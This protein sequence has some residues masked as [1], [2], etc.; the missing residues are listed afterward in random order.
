MPFPLEVAPAP[1]SCLTTLAGGRGTSP[2]ASRF[3][4]LCWPALEAGL[5]DVPAARLFALVAAVVAVTRAVITVLGSLVV[6][7]GFAREAAVRPGR[8]VAFSLSLR[9]VVRPA[10]RVTRRVCYERRCEAAGTVAHGCKAL[11]GM[12]EDMKR[13][14]RSCWNGRTGWSRTELDVDEHRRWRHGSFCSTPATN[15]TK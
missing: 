2:R 9:T 4:L 5:E 3:R 14:Q 10:A 15:T 12:A 8:A 6:D 7:G 1:G 11:T 13:Q